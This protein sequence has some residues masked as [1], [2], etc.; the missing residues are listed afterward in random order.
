MCSYY[1]ILAAFPTPYGI[2][3][4]PSYSQQLVPPTP[5]VKNLTVLSDFFCLYK[6]LQGFPGGSD[7]K[8]SACKVGDPDSIPGQEDPLER[9]R[10]LTPV[11]LS[12]EFHGQRSLAGYSPWGHKE[13]D[14]TEQ[15]IHTK[16][17]NNVVLVS[18][19]QQNDSAMHIHLSILFL[20][21]S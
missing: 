9:E 6:H 21:C 12:G 2:S 3:L 19:V 7:S 11:F 8:K 10:L 1:K 16:L 17:S 5:T 4:S 15:L 13:P 20:A 14:M 18:G